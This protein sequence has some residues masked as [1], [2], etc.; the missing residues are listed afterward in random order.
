MKPKEEDLEKAEKYIK[1]YIYDA[2]ADYFPE[3][4]YK[5]RLESLCRVYANQIAMCAYPMIHNDVVQVL[6]TE[7]LAGPEFNTF[8]ERL[9][10]NEGYEGIMLR[11]GEAPY[12]NKRTKSLIKVKSFCEDEFTILDVVVG[13]GNRSGEAGRVTLEIN[14]KS[15]GAGIKGD[16]SYRLYLL[17]NKDHLIGKKGTVEYFQLTEDGVPRFPVFKA[18]RDYD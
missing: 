1:Y 14:G 12:Q 18:V 6:Y 17:Q 3:N 10:I 5:D 8:I 4:P 16:A 2:V 9:V 13:R 15:F 11:D 7:K